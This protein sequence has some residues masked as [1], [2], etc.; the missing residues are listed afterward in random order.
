M[1]R[2]IIEKSVVPQAGNKDYFDARRYF[3]RERK[4]GKR[5]DVTQV[6]ADMLKSGQYF[7]IQEG[8]KG[9]AMGRI[10]FRFKNKFAIY[11]HDTSSKGVFERE[12]RGVSHGCI[13]LEKP[14][15]FAV[16]LLGGKDEKTIERIRYSM[17]ADIHP[18]YMDDNPSSDKKQS[19]EADR[20]D[21][22]KLIK[23]VQ[24][25]PTVPLFITYYTLYPNENNVMTEYPDVYGFDSVIYHQLLNYLP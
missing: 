12:Y 24:V 4:T 9:N 25:K 13:R 22:A 14:F 7:V 17:E 5:M 8:G 15:D 11:L 3:I 10:V 19:V 6:S 21:R 1:P 20:L 2:S 16:F 23:S 18:T